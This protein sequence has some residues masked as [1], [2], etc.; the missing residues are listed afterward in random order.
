[1][2]TQK[3]LGTTAFKAKDFA[4]AAEHFGKAIEEDPRDHAL[5]S[6]RSACYHNLKQHEEALGDAEMCINLKSDWGKGHQRKAMALHGMGHLDEAYKAY[7][8]GLKVD[9]DNSQIKS[10]MQAVMK[11]QQADA[12]RGGGF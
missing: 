12:M 1:M 5:F 3:E 11:D 6:N 9:P 7:Q 10:G 2:S 4:T 8:E